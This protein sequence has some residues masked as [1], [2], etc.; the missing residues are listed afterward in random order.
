ML[1]SGQAWRVW[2][3]TVLLAVAGNLFVRFV[4]VEVLDVSR[5]FA[6]LATSGPTVLLTLVGVVT[7]LVVAFIVGKMFKEPMVLFRRI[8]VI[9][10]VLS[11]GPDMWLF[12]EAG[13]VAFPGVN[14]AAVCTLMLQHV[15][16]AVVVLRMVAL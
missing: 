8:S 10:L 12:T 16:A 4:A 5:E 11:F 2:L 14:I 15:L 7:G 6:P 1:R 13:S 3:R 9:A